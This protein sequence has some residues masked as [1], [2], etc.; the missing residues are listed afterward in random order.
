MDNLLALMTGID[1]P[2]PECKLIIHQPK[3]KEIAFIGER[4][5]FLGA[6]TLCVDKSMVA[7]GKTLLSDISN[8]QILMTIM[9]EDK[10]K[11]EAVRDV[12]MLLFPEYKITQTPRAIMFAREGADMVMIDKDT[13]DI[14][15]VTLNDIFCF[16]TGASDQSTFKPANDR[17][18]EIAQKLMRARAR[19][20]AEKGESGSGSLSQYLSTLTVGLGSMSLEDCMNLTL[21][22]LYDLLER[23]S[24]YMNWD[25]DIRSRLAGGKPDSQP[26]NWMKNIH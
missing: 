10:D 26:D 23:Y 24:L 22:Q 25:I 18:R 17:A 19:V 11:K 15:Q 4:K 20:A 7:Q 16:N 13:L 6:Q 12:L 1:I 2:V 3:L 8:F 21:F 5:Y 9:S 14:L